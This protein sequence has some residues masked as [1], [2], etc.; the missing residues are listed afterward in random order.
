V[1][2]IKAETADAREGTAGQRK[3]A[4]RERRLR[5]QHQQTYMVIGVIVAVV[6]IAVVIVGWASQPL[7]ITIPTSFSHYEGLPVSTTSGGF[8]RLGAED[9]PVLIEDLSSFTCPHCTEMHKTLTRLIDPYIRDGT[10]AVVFVPLASSQLAALGAQAAICA[11]EQG[12]FWQMQDVLFSWVENG[13][14]PYNQRHV[15]AAAGRLGLDVDALSACLN[16]P[17]TIDVLQRA[18]EEAV[19]RGVSGTPALFFN[20]ERPNCGN[21]NNPLCEGDLPYDIIVQNI[22]QHLAGR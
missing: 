3:A 10:V 7:E 9:A 12:K 16:A 19:A 8:Y 21:V 17:E 22:E 15:E 1:S 4:A 2:K 11:G 18:G 13:N 14:I 6:A 5:Q 20:G